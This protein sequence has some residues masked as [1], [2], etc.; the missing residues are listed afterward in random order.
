VRGQSRLGDFLLLA[1]L[2]GIIAGAIIQ[3]PVKSDEAHDELLA[4]LEEL[5]TELPL[6]AP[7]VLVMGVEDPDNCGESWLD[8][9]SGMFFIHV[10]EG[11]DW[12]MQQW[13]VI[14][15]YAHCMTWNSDTD[16]GPAWAASY[17]E[18]Y[19]AIFE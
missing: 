5:R 1:I 12:R 4:T 9:E 11:I 19:R 14:H 18:A 17:A 6:G 13:I 15:E 2:C 10:E 16:H 3:G 8:E 7:V